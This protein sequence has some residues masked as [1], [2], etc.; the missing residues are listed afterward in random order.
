MAQKVTK[1][2]LI[3][4]K[5]MLLSM[6]HP[7]WGVQDCVSRAV[8]WVSDLMTLVPDPI[9]TVYVVAGSGVTEEQLGTK[10]I[11]KPVR[12]SRSRPSDH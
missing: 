10:A 12:K 11:P 7:S 4:I 6:D 3:R 8:P 9:E 1:Q 5:A 2:D